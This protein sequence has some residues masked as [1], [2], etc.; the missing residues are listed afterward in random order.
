MNNT[1]TDLDSVVSLL[2]RELQKQQQQLDQLQRAVTEL[3][4]GA[5]R[6]AVHDL[7]RAAED[8]DG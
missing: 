8:D 1:H 2:W 7:V 4:A 6:R 3:Q 5:R